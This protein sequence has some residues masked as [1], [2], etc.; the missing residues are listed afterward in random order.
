MIEQPATLVHGSFHPNNIIISGSRVCP[1]DWEL[2]A[3]GNRLY[4]FA[5]IADGFDEPRLQVMWQAYLA[6]FGETFRAPPLHW[7]A[8]S[9]VI[10]CFRIHKLLKHLV[11]CVVWNYPLAAV[12]KQQA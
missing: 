6:G 2:A 5:F 11:E 4:D 8:A 3:I 7:P 12:E 10:D 9:L 1:V